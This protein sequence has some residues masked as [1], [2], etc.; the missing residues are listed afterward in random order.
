VYRQ[1]ENFPRFFGVPDSAGIVHPL[2]D[3]PTNPYFDVA[4]RFALEN[5]PSMANAALQ[6]PG[7]GKQREKI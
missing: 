6:A 3:K 5:R 2:P 4:Q 1:R 7:K